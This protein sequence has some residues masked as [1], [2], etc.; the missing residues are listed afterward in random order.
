MIDRSAADYNS[1]TYDRLGAQLDPFWAYNP[2]ARHRRRILLG[3]LDRISFG[4]L[5]DVGCG[6]GAFLRLLQGRYPHA[7]FAGADLSAALVRDD[8][9]RMPSMEFFPLDVQRGGL[10]RTFDAITCA[11]VIE[12]L[13]DRAAA[14]GHLAAMLRPGGHLLVSC[15]T[16]RVYETERVFGHTSHPS[17]GELRSLARAAGLRVVRSQNWGF[18]LYRAMKWATNVRPDFALE[19]FASG[20]YG[21]GQIAVSHALYAVNFLNARSSPAGCQLFALLQKP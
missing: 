4:A 3:Y 2:G 7:R 13:D 14:F 9:E 10:D 20:T 19:R 18:P 8:R 1:E 17:E 11:E 12:H 5:L 21:A 15:P 16:G 6:N